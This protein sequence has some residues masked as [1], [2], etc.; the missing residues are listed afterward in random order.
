MEIQD[1]EDR[2]E[3]SE[4][5]ALDGPYEY[6]LDQFSPNSTTGTGRWISSVGVLRTDGD[7]RAHE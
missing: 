5:V 1:V 6:E 3:G 2:P 7:W 4:E